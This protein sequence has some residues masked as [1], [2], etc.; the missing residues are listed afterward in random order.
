MISMRGQQCKGGHMKLEPFVKKTNSVRYFSCKRIEVMQSSKGERIAVLC[1]KKQF[2]GVVRSTLYNDLI[3]HHI[4]KIYVM[5]DS[6]YIYIRERK[7]GSIYVEARNNYYLDVSSIGNV[8]LT[9]TPFFQLRNEMRR[10]R[11]TR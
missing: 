11:V 3:A 1:L 10:R 9:Q 7:D 8:W 5:G 2:D 4:D 6:K